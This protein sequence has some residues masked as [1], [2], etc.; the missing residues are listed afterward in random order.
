MA[1][2]V[3]LSELDAG[4]ASYSYGQAGWTFQFGPPSAGTHYQVR[5]VAE[6]QG[7]AGGSATVVTQ[8]GVAS[9]VGGSAASCRL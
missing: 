1:R 8:G 6:M 7:I 4:S 2:Q 5:A 3:R 9:D